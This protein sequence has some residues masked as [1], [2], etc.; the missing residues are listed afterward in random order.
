MSACRLS[1]LAERNRMGVGGGRRCKINIYDICMLIISLFSHSIAHL[2]KIYIKNRESTNARSW[3]NQSWYTHHRC[4][5]Q[6]QMTSWDL[7]NFS[8]KVINQW[9]LL[10]D[11][12]FST[13]MTNQFKNYHDKLIHKVWYKLIHKVWLIKLSISNC[14]NSCMPLGSTQ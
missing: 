6:D 4:S 7:K 9:S 2:K 14:P 13:E 1:T 10:P 8:Q 3:I 5:L 12:I 11:N